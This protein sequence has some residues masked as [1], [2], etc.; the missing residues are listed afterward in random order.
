MVDR[1]AQYANTHYVNDL[2]TN[3]SMLEDA[4]K[5]MIKYAINKE[6]DKPKI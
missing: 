3:T 2:N 4:D 1:L 5:E 6:W